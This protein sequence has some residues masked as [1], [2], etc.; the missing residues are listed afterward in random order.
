MTESAGI[1]DFNTKRMSPEEANAHAI[2]QEWRNHVADWRQ[3]PFNIAKHFPEGVSWFSPDQPWFFKSVLSDP[4]KV[5]K[6]QDSDL[7]ILSG[8]GMSAYKYQEKDQDAYSQEDREYVEQAENLVRNHLGEGKRVLGI[9][10]GGQIAALSV[11]ARLGRLPNNEFGNAVT[12]AGWLDHEL[13]EAG[14]ADAVFGNLPEKFYAPHLHSDFVA[15]L[16]K[17]GTVIKTSGGEIEVTRAN[18][19]AIRHG[20]LDRDGLKNPK[21]IYI[22]ASIIE[23]NNGA[24]LYQVQPHP[25]MATADKANFLVRM[26]QGWLGKPEEMGEEYLNN[27]LQIPQDADFSAAK[28]IPNFVEEYRKQLQVD[29]VQAKTP[30]ILHELEQYLVK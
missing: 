12:E 10:Y 30:A 26:N 15:E 19:L 22:H 16:P 17:V 2:P 28:I 14:K 25:E 4:E 3:Y 11:G 13:T 1:I 9:C 21:E 7:L 18:V 23:F 20:Y 29:L 24:V 5:A 27:A 8:S 6:L